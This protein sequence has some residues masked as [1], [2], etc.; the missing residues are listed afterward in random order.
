MTIN[1]DKLL[2]I[3][4]SVGNAVVESAYD[5]SND[6]GSTVRTAP[7]TVNP[8][9][10]NKETHQIRQGFRLVREQTYTSIPLYYPPFER[11]DYIGVCFVFALEEIDKNNLA[12][13]HIYHKDLNITNGFQYQAETLYA[14]NKPLH[15]VSLQFDSDFIES[16]NEQQSIPKWLL[17]LA[18]YKDGYVLDRMTVSPILRHL[19]WQISQLPLTRLLSDSLRIES[20]A[21]DWLARMIESYPTHKPINDHVLVGNDLANKSKRFVMLACD[22][23]H[24]EYSQPLTIREL[25][26][27]VGTNASYLKQ[28]FKSYTGQSIHEYL[29]HYRLRQAQNLLI[30]QPMLNIQIVAELCGYQAGYFSQ[31]FKDTYGISPSHYRQTKIAE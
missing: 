19:A 3:T 24:K 2:W 15:Y 10:V 20:K 25:A 6:V 18:S 11:T 30:L 14:I 16:L 27:R 1:Y 13:K 21:L 17:S 9:A 5:D 23:I 22:I 4:N 31:L 7:V 12:F 28:Y 26:L 29:T 8:V